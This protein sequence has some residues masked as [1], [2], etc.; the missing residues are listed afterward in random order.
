[1]TRQRAFVIRLSSSVVLCLSSA[2]APAQFPPTR[3]TNLRIL[4]K[5]IAIDS[6]INVMGGFTRALGV[7][8]NYCHV[9]REGQTFEQIDFSLDDNP[10]KNKAR[11]MLRMVAAINNDHLSALA[12]RRQPEI[13]VACITCHRGVAEPRMLQQVL[14]ATYTVAGADSTESV[15][16]SLRH[17]Y[18]GSG[19]YDFGEVPLADVA[20]T[21]AGRGKPTDALRF[22]T[23]NTEM[24]PRST[25]ALRQLGESY[26][27]VGDTAAARGAYRRA[28]T[29]NANDAQSRRALDAL[30]PRP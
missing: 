29:I 8:C 10:R 26:L 4:P 19:S 21:I 2:R 7:R 15:Y 14:L 5:D 13:V 18:F 30:E 11:A 12:D 20:A 25:F 6:L 1:M 3:A 16:R 24:N 23:L 17:R 9:Q 22:H 27:A 28:L